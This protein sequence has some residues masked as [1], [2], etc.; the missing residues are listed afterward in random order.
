MS[1]I[2]IVYEREM[3]QNAL[4]KALSELGHTV[5]RAGNGVDALEAARRT[6]PNLVISDILL[7]KMDGF[8]LC[9]KWKQ[10]ERLQPL[11]FMFYTRKYD[12]P[13]YQR[14]ASELSA[15]CFMERSNDR[16]PLLQAVEELLSSGKAAHKLDPIRAQA[17]G[18]GAFLVTSKI[19]VEPVIEPE[20]AT[21]TFELPLAP[22]APPAAKPASEAIAAPARAKPKTKSASDGDGRSVAREMKLMSKVT[23]LDTLNKQLQASEQKFQSLFELSPTP[24]WVL[25][26]EDR[27]CT[28]VNKAALSLYGYSHDEFIALPHNEP[29]FAAGEPIH[30]SSATWHR[31]KFG[32]AVAVELSTRVVEPKAK[33]EIV[34]AHDVT[35]RINA[36]RATAHAADAYQALLI[37]AAD[38]FLLLDEQHRL[39]DVNEAYCRM[40]GYRRDELLKLTPSDLEM[41]V[42][43]ETSI[44]LQQQLAEQKNYESVHRRKD[45]TTYPV[46]VSIGSLTG[47]RS[48]TVLLIRDISMRPKQQAQIDTQT[49]NAQ[50]AALELLNSAPL[51]D[52]ATFLQHVI[53]RCANLSA[54]PLAFFCGVDDSGT[55]PSLRAVFE[56]SRRQAITVTGDARKLNAKNLSADCLSSGQALFGHD[57]QHSE[58]CAS[59]PPQHTLLMLPIERD[60]EALGVLAVANRDER[61]SV[62]DITLLSPIIEGLTTVLLSKRKQ[63]ASLLVA[64]RAEVALQRL[65]ENLGKDAAARGA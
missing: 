16:A 17:L 27:H 52:D 40:S 51:L 10:D 35:Q 9:K 20:V 42:G 26:G 59:L 49:V 61:Y 53:E 5:M 60:G 4:D 45:L 13:K 41:R 19:S 64:Q 22:I 29:P 6:P 63:A 12:D 47:A 7:P 38:G 48:R 15:D 2:L 1:T 8:A 37:A 23:E 33:R 65:I 24:M 11:P 21:T 58:A 55:T 46:E 54:S 39:L 43:D 30:G 50:Q 18:T 62:A 31:T 44:R 34:V 14:F 36:E 28:D 25:Q 57:A 56:A 3:E 32:T